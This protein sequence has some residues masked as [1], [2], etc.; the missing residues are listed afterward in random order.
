MA[1]RNERTFWLHAVNPLHVGS[2]RERYIDLPIM[3]EKVTA[4]PF[5]PGFTVKGVLLTNSR[6]DPREM[7]R[8]TESKG[9]RNGRR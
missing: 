5:I 8:P 9:F 7:K 6:H 2:G 4:W 1:K 3:R